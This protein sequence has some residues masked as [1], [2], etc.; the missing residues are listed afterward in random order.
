MTILDNIKTYFSKH[1]QKI[2][3][4]YNGF[5]PTTKFLLETGVPLIGDPREITET[6]RN[7]NPL[8]I[9]GNIADARSITNHMGQ[10]N[11]KCKIYKELNINNTNNLFLKM[12]SKM[13][14][15]LHLLS[16]GNTVLRD[17]LFNNIN[18]FFSKLDNPNKTPNEIVK[19]PFSDFLKTSKV[20]G[21]MVTPMTHPQW[22]NNND[23]HQ[24]Y[25]Y[26][27]RQHFDNQS[28]M[29]AT[30]G[31]NDPR[32]ISGPF[33]DQSEYRKRFVG[34]L[35][36]LPGAGGDYPE[37]KIKSINRK[38]LNLSSYDQNSQFTVGGKKSTAKKSTAKKSTA[39]KSTAKKSTAKKSTAKKST[40]KKSTAKKSTAKKN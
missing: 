15:I 26:N 33:D 38:N 4:T 21:R 34:E 23:Y 40:A 29:Q 28:L 36:N 14:I 19:L 11:M 16:I 27:T 17:I 32:E 24:K 13:E 39:K 9:L 12:N 5:H 2:K 6:V 10:L 7:L 25:V 3:N 1:S 35:A 22:F 18:E 8:D 20:N 30:G 37:P 31:D